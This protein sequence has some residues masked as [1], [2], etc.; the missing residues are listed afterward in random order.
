M[1]KKH[2]SKLSLAVLVMALAAPAFAQHAST[3]LVTRYSDRQGLISELVVEQPSTYRA[4]SRIFFSVSGAP[5]AKASVSA[6]TSRGPKTIPLSETDPGR[7]E[8]F[9]TVH[10]SDD[11]TR[12]S[13]TARLEK[14]GQVSEAWSGSENDRSWENRGQW[15]HDNRD[16]RNDHDDEGDRYNR[17][18]RHGRDAR[19]R[20]P[21]AVC[22]VCGSISM[23]QAVDEGSSDASAPGI[24]IGGLVGGLL[25]NQ[26]GGGHGK[27][28]TTILGA[29]GGGFLG[30]EIGKN[31]NQRKAWVITVNLDNGSSQSFRNNERPNVQ[32]GQRVRVENNQLYPESR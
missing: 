16:N 23:I 30:N 6:Q 28:A 14:R 32:I 22:A 1:N 20:E 5:G 24:I 26:V 9:Y 13:F 8:G 25:G 10:G 29:L 3:G 31:Q 27:D 7:Y 21:Q 15:S 2:A 17:D 18:A 12:P 19:G 4:G 11:F